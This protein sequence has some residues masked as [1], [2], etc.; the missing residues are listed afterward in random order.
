M[1]S[2]TEF[3]FGEIGLNLKR[4]EIG[5]NLKRLQIGLNLKWLQILSWGFLM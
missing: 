5:L 2:L 3:V 4:L 1:A